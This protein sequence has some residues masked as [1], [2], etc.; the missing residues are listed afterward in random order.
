MKEAEI[1]QCLRLYHKA[2]DSYCKLINKLAAAQAATHGV[3][4]LRHTRQRLFEAEEDLSQIGEG[5]SV[6]PELAE[7]IRAE[8]RLRAQEGFVGRPPSADWDEDLPD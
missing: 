8:R 7:E 4:G 1:N 5:I 6:L 2:V 3:P